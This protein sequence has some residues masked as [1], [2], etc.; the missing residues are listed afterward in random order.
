ML[1]GD[2]LVDAELG[3]LEDLVLRMIVLTAVPIEERETGS[4]D[5]DIA[6]VDE[7]GSYLCIPNEVGGSAEAFLGSLMWRPICR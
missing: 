3:Y 5:E 6:A 1:V 7:S 2:V 4:A